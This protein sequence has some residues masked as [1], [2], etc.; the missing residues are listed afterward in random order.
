MIYPNNSA[1]PVVVT[2]DAMRHETDTGPTIRE[3][4]SAMFLAAL[5]SKNG[6]DEY[7]VG[8]SVAIADELIRTLNNDVK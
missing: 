6:Y 8:R 1:F 7:V 5:L 3:Q 2:T 4:W